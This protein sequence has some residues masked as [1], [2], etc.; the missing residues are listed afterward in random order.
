LL[1]DFAFGKGLSVPTARD[2]RVQKVIDEA[3]TDPN[4][5]EKLTG[6]AA[7]RKLSNE[8]LTSGELFPTLYQ[9]AGRVRVGRLDADTVVNIVP[10]PEDRL[11]PLWFVAL[12]RH[13]EWD[14]KEDRPKFTDEL[15]RDGRR[16]VKYWKHWR[17]VDDAIKEREEGN[18][19]ESEND[20]ALPEP[21]RIAKGVVYHLAINQTG[22]QL[23]G[24]PPWAR[25][26]RFFTAMNVLTE[27]HVTM[28][29]AASTFIA[30]RAMK[31]TPKQIAKAASAI[32]TSV[33]ELGSAALSGSG[34]RF[35][36]ERP[37]PTTMPFTAPGTPPPA[38]P[39]SWWNE[40]DSSELSAL[41]LNS[42]AAQMAQT[43][44]IVR[45]PLAASSGFGQ[46]YLG[47]A[48]NANLSSASTLELPATMHIGAWQE[49]FETLYRWFTDRAIE[50]A[51]KEGLLGGV[52]GFA[53]KPLAEMRLQEAGDREAMSERTGVDLTYE[54]TM[55]FPGR[56]QLTDVSAVV[57]ETLQSND[58]LGLNIPLRRRMLRFLFEQMG[59]DDVAGAVD[60]CVPESGLPGGGEGFQSMPPGGEEGGERE[61]STSA[62]AG[63]GAAEP[64][65][66]QQQP[67]GA[68][69]KGTQLQE[70]QRAWLPSDALGQ[71]DALN[72]D[73]TRMWDQMVRAPAL[74]A[75]LALT[76]ANGNGGS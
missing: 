32:L 10:D 70:A 38:P 17:N 60:E 18:L 19:G 12:E 20:L 59:M 64:K 65:G 28:A 8:L 22:E 40:N 47:D 7:Q 44:Q 39:G 41:N 49:G 56:R 54:F 68:K 29:Q 1:G 76:A 21:D 61:G 55:P 36:S 52:D 15:G 66:E 9:N 2:E 53:G 73:T 37:E 27:A 72:G 5:E 42:G 67:Y 26:L 43:A 30:R 14:Y 4:N 74:K 50:A 16:K 45:A 69:S 46:H 23:R 51:V 58:P 71:V 11:R 63:A 25:S 75:V 48:S 57:S 34:R 33:G 3:W 6:Y 35:P 13:F 62:K 24:N 31:G